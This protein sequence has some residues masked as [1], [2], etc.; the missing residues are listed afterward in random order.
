MYSYTCFSAGIKVSFQRETERTA[1]ERGR[2]QQ[3][4]KEMEVKELGIGE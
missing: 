4:I 2:R 1:E 3:S